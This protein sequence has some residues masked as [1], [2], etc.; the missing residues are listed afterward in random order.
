MLPTPQAVIDKVNSLARDQPSLI[1]FTDRQ[2]NEIGSNDDDNIIPPEL[3]LQ[4]S[5][6]IPGVVADIAPIT[7][8]DMDMGGTENK[9]VDMDR[10]ADTDQMDDLVNDSW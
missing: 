8:V 9:G 1:T 2:G 3:N 4:T 7:G 6:K 10:T 5:Y